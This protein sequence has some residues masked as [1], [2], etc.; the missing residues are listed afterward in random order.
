[1]TI[2]DNLNKRPE[3]TI[4]K[5][6]DDP[7]RFGQPVE[8][9]KDVFTLELE[10]FFNRQDISASR[11]SEVP[12]IRKFD[13]ST[14]ASSHE[15]AVQIIQ[16]LPDLDENLPLVAILGAN[17]RNMFMG[18]GGQFVNSVVV[19]SFISSSNTETYALQDQQTLKF[20]TITPQKT[21][22]VT[23]I[24]FRTSRFVD[25]TLATA[26]EVVNEIVFQ[27]L[28]ATALVNS[29]DGVD[30]I[31]GGPLSGG[32]LGDIII[33]DGNGD[34][35]TAAAVLGFTDG[36]SAL[37]IDTIAKNRYLQSSSVDIAIEVVAEDYNVRTELVD[38]V[39]TFF[40]FYMDERDYMFFGRSIFNA[41]IPDE[42]YQIIIKPD[43]SISGESEVPR[44]GDEVDKLFVNRINI[45]VTT[46][47]YT[48]RAVVTSGGAPLYRDASTVSIEDTIPKP[49]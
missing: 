8:T 46:I 28:F 4:P 24:I 2:I 34:A 29:S 20:R 3:A 39:W 7:P 25:I 21:E 32:S 1:M 47:Q 23:T 27:S 45:P 6:T 5:D 49:N 22:K 30:L 9:T 16:K 17:V 10:K 43:L 42:T 14:T 26:Q 44:P 38:L 33:G 31:Y 37:F 12:T 36:Q 13:I 19:P 11:R 41:S 18:I 48:D 15:T 40:T 35:G